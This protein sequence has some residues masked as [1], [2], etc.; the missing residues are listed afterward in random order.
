[1]LELGILFH[2][3]LALIRVIPL[4]LVGCTISNLEKSINFSLGV[5]YILIVI[6]IFFI[7]Q[8]YDHLKNS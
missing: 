8:I 2:I 4:D 7:K 3:D 6:L 1:M 5:C